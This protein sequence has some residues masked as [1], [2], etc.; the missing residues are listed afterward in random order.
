MPLPR[1]PHRRIQRARAH[2]IL[3]QH[4]LQFLDEG[5][6]TGPYI[7]SRRPASETRRAFH[8]PPGVCKVDAYCYIQRCRLKMGSGVDVHKVFVHGELD[9][10]M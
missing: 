3:L 8:C 1:L 4:L 6:L 2:A 9:R 5:P 7:G 10:D